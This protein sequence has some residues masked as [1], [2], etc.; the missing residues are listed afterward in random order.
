MAKDTSRFRSPA[1]HDSPGD[2]SNFSY[3][4]TDD[5]TRGMTAVASTG[6]AG[7]ILAPTVP[8]IMSSG[9]VILQ[10]TLTEV[11]GHFIGEH[12]MYAVCAPPILKDAV[13]F[14]EGTPFQSAAVRFRRSQTDPGATFDGLSGSGTCG[15]RRYAYH[16]YREEYKQGGVSLVPVSYAAWETDDSSELLLL[17][18]DPSV[19]VSHYRVVFLHGDIDMDL[20]AFLEQKDL[21]QAQLLRWAGHVIEIGTEADNVPLGPFHGT[22]HQSNTFLS[23]LSEHSIGI[24]VPDPAVSADNPVVDLEVSPDGTIYLGDREFD[25]IVVA[26]PL[27]SGSRDL[28][29][30]TG[31]AQPG[32]TGLAITP[33]GHLYT[34]NAASDSRFGGRLFRFKPNGSREY[35]GQINYFSSLVG[36]ANPVAAIA[37]AADAEGDLYVADNFDKQIKKLPMAQAI[38]EE[39]PSNRI[40]AKGIGAEL[41]TGFSSFTDMAFKGGN[42]FVS[43]FDKLYVWRP[44]GQALSEYSTIPNAHFTGLAT[45]TR[46]QL[47]IACQGVGQAGEKTGFVAVLPNGS[48]GDIIFNDEEGLAPYI[49]LHDMT[50]TGDIEIG[51]DGK[52]LI[53][54]ESGRVKAQYFGV[55]GQ[56]VDRHGQ[57]M[58]STGSKVYVKSY[59]DIGESQWVQADEHGIFSIM[60]LLAPGQDFKGHPSKPITLSIKQG[61]YI[62]ERQ[63]QLHSTGQTILS[64]THN[65]YEIVFSPN[66]LKVA[67]GSSYH[68]DYSVIERGTSRDVTADVY[69]EGMVTLSPG[70]PELVAI[71]SSGPGQFTINALQEPGYS[72]TYSAVTLTHPSSGKIITTGIVSIYGQQYSVEMKTDPCSEVTAPSGIV[73]T[74]CYGDVPTEMILARGRTITFIADVFDGLGD[75]IIDFG[76]KGLTVELSQ[77]KGLA[78]FIDLDIIQNAP[79]HVS[80]TI[81]PDA[82]EGS[83]YSLSWVLKRSSDNQVVDRSQLVTIRVRNFSI[84]KEV[85]LDN[86]PPGLGS[87]VDYLIKITNYSDQVISGDFIDTIPDVLEI[88]A[89]TPNVSHSGNLIEGTMSIAPDHEEVISIGCEV[90]DTAFDSVTNTASFTYDETT[91][92]DSA[93]F[94]AKT[95]LRRAGAARMPVRG[96][97]KGWKKIFQ[98]RTSSGWKRN[99]PPRWDCPD[100]GCTNDAITMVDVDEDWVTLYGTTEIPLEVEIEGGADTDTVSFST[101]VDSPHISFSNPVINMNKTGAI[102]RAATTL[103]VSDMWLDRHLISTG[104]KHQFIKLVITVATESH[105]DASYEIE[106]IDNMHLIDDMYINHPALQRVLGWNVGDSLSAISGKNMIA[107]SG[108]LRYWLVAISTQ[109]QCTTYGAEV[110]ALLNDLRGRENTTWLFNGIDYGPIQTNGGWR[111]E[112]EQFDAHHYAVSIY[113]NGYFLEP[114]S[115]VLDPWRHQHP[116]TFEYSDWYAYMW[117]YI[118]YP[119]QESPIPRVYEPEDYAPTAKELNVNY[120]NS[121]YKNLDLGYPAWSDSP[122]QASWN[123]GEADERET[124]GELW[125]H[126]KTSDLLLK[127]RYPSFALL[128]P[129][130]FVIADEDGLRYGEDDQGNVYNEI[131]DISKDIVEEPDIVSG[132]SHYSFNRI[133]PDFDLTLHPKENSTASLV[134]LRVLPDDSAAIDIYQSFPIEVG[135]PIQF[136]PEPDSFDAP[137]LVYDDGTLRH[138][139]KSMH[140]FTVVEATPPDG[141]IVTNAN[142]TLTAKLSRPLEEDEM[143]SISF[144]LMHNNGYKVATSVEYDEDSR[145]LALTPHEPLLPNS[146]YKA[147]LVF[148]Q[149]RL[150][151]N[152]VD[153]YGFEWRF[154]TNS[155]EGEEQNY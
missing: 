26:D 14:D 81:P 118:N 38:E 140:V 24:S 101:N 88:I 59:S 145:T 25:E 70:D 33:L 95:R 32:Q 17:D 91:K 40:V 44:L 138:A 55:S 72:G 8:S 117:R 9:N 136:S 134:T 29:V 122:S 97:T 108:E 87:D 150:F 80:L 111:S 94:G 90:V 43:A 50:F 137:A 132:H 65:P 100:G 67:A 34:D 135:H 115:Y 37:I 89:T 99:C 133:L 31:F 18:P 82:N 28:F 155:F 66:V 144:V 69:H 152:T 142:L 92:T 57:P 102:G 46:E 63:V 123:V 49:F 2:P 154:H 1:V 36:Q 103:Q 52:A 139:D 71:G 78:G 16:L 113:P 45:D 106:F 64:V 76:T 141:V 23:R 10:G 6:M 48:G 53:Y 77:E 112:C 74:E 148:S 93:V 79:G 12:Y 61:G 27:G 21:N 84:S 119:P 85:I 7:I 109:T 13:V 153:D 114:E 35:A 128:S 146:N 75:Q 86:D 121:N 73:Y 143:D 15:N 105:G 127:T 51:P 147:S 120:P 58:G 131:P 62:E 129:L 116:V 41:P 68:I 30:N 54:T 104:Y 126:P 60:G 83:F 98:E 39:W 110:L 20:N 125:Y 130:S 149:I 56:L 5:Y 42:L 22:L 3:Y 151:E 19:G 96:V 4:M 11:F 124:W 47:Y 107:I